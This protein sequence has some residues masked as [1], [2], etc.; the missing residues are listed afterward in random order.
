MPEALSTALMLPLVAALLWPQ[1]STRA[2]ALL[3]IAGGVLWFVRPNSGGAFFLMGIVAFAF[4]RHLRRLAGFFTGFIAVTV[5]GLVSLHPAPPGDPVHGLGYQ[6]LEASANYYWTPSIGQ[7]PVE[8]TPDA[9]ARAEMRRAAWNWANLLR[10]NSADVRRELAWRALH[11]LFGV[12]YYDARWSESY[13]RLSIAGRILSPFL[14][15]SALAFLAAAPW[16]AEM[17]PRKGTGILLLAII[18]GQNL[19]LGSNPRYVLPFIPVLFLIAISTTR[20]VF[21]ISLNR[22]AVLTIAFAIFL[23]IVALH[24]YALDWQWGQIERAGVSLVQPISRGALP[25]HS[26]AALHIRI[27]SPLPRSAANLRILGPGE[28]ILYVS[29]P[30]GKRASPYVTI[31][32]SEEIL[33]ENSQRAIELRLESFGEYNQLNYL[34]FPVIPWPWAISARRG[35]EAALSPGTG[36]HVGGLDWWAHRGYP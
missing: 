2:A 31:P 21:P 32:L 25:A 18:V 20:A 29:L 30:D 16:T 15:I 10:Q 28:R 17:G 33:R 9:M 23:L 14:L 1:A 4:S 7:W 35:D 27:A 22:V 24:R 11:G 6:I 8:Y 12:E 36:I 13:R 34:L 5:L 19:I 3:G 26:P